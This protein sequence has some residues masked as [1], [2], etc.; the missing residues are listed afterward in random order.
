EP[1][2]LIDSDERI[3]EAK[4]TCNFYTQN[5]LYKGPCEHILA[6]RISHSRQY[7]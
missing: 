6:L 3:A 1:E 5:K 2:V 7:L 4:C